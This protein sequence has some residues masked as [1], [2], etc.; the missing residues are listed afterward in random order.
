MTIQRRLSFAA[1]AAVAIAV[2]LASVGAYVAVR[3]KLRGE[4]DSSLRDRAAAAQ[5]LVERTQSLGIQVPGPP[6][7]GDEARFGGAQGHVQFVDPS[8]RPLR[9]GS[10][11]T[12][13]VDPAAASIAKGAGKA[14]LEDAH[15]A[16]HHLRVVTAPLPGGGAIQVARPLDEVDSVLHG[17]V[18]LLAGITI[19]GVLLAAVLGGV[20]SRASLRPVRRFTDETESIASAPDLGRRLEVESDDELGRLARSFNST[21]EALERSAAAQRHLVADASHELRTP[22]ASLKTN[23]EVLLTDRRLPPAERRE[24]LRDLVEQADE[25]TLLV[26]DI[27]EL[28]RKGEATAEAFDDVPVHELVERA[29]ERAR[30]HAPDLEYHVELEPLTVHGVPDRLD[31]AVA[32]LLDNAAKWSPPGATVDVLLED[33]ELIVRDR[34]PGFKDEDLPYVFDRFYRASEARKLPGSGL[35]LAIVRQVAEAHGSTVRASNAPG[36]GACLRLSFN[37]AFAK[38]GPPADGGPKLLSAS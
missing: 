8:G 34:G 14:K 32:N 9:Q 18:L 2:A 3:A 33:G 37:G 35:G 30:R 36:G 38:A 31:R 1:A 24:L 15:V 17:L 5:Q 7:V 25:L 21:L 22:L 16:G 12:I 13:P 11:V 10:K 6:P 4:V 28:A 23:L 26:G 29:V 20:V 27:V 19:G